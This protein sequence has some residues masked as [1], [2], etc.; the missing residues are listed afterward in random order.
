[1]RLKL[2]TRIVLG[3]CVIL[4]MAA[5][6][7]GVMTYQVQQIVTEIDGLQKH[8]IRT[9]E[10]IAISYYVEEQSSLIK[11]YLITGSPDDKA[12]V[13]QKIKEALQHEEDLIKITRQKVNLDRITKVHELNKQMEQVFQN[14]IVPLVE[15]GQ[16]TEALRV[17]TEQFNPLANQ[18]KDAV[19]AYVD[20]K[21]QE[22][23][24]AENNSLQASLEAKKAAVSFGVVAVLLGLL[25]SFL[26]SRAITRPINR[27]VQETTVVA[28]GDLTQRVEVIGEDELAQ[29]ARAFNR[30]VENLHQMAKQVVDKSTGLAAHSQELSAATQQVS[31]SVEEITGSTTELAA[32]AQQEAAGAGNAVEV[33]RQVQLVAEQGDQAVG[34]A[35]EKMNAI[36]SRVDQSSRQVAR[37]GERSRDIGKITD[38][39]TGIADQT[40]LLALNAAI[41][42]ARAGEQGRG[43]AVVAEE[44]RK[45]AEQSSQAAKEISQIIKQIQLETEQAVKDMSL[46]VQE[47]HQGTQVVDAAGQ[48]LKKILE[49]VQETVTIIEEI[50]RG[51]EQNSQNSQNLAAAT[52]QVSAN[53]QQIASTAQDLAKMGDEFQQ[54]VAN[55]KV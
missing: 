28:G 30:M 19:N 23:K 29:L 49:H 20:Y 31:A 11:E 46:G 52:Q 38:V 8:N 14:Q 9:M 47:V 18:L 40:N 33:T 10:G 53:V 55:F 22:S 25:F 45:L 48:A 2:T 26:F 1:M 7:A 44:V 15:Q 17:K 34:Q 16:T 21:K 41:E 4:A 54:L 39:I 37:L 51:A 3:Y 6:L 50:A 36:V 35:V 24:L 27:L 5:L 13:E 43:F 12:K 42:A 32:A